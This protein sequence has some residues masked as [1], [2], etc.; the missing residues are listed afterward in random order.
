MI[1]RMINEAGLKSG[2]YAIILPM[3]SSEQ[4]TAIYY[5]TKSFR[6]A[7]IN[8][9]YGIKCSKDE[10]N[11]VPKADSILQAKLI[12]IT[13]GDQS[14]FMDVVQG[15]KVEQAIRQAHMKGATIAGTS[16]GAAVMSE[17]M[18]TGNQ[19]K[20]SEYTSTFATIE[21][22]NLET[23]Q[24]LGMIKNAIIDQH[25]VARSRHNRLLTAILES[26]ELTGIGIDESTAILVINNRAEV[27]GMSQVLVFKNRRK[28]VNLNLEKLGGKGIKVDIYLPGNSFRI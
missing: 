27:I 6:E 25:F 2:G 4:D 24:G 3:S 7:G 9:V 23:R 8:N 19:L 21:K 18:I 22:N 20:E 15:S 28:R 26:P 1:N 5:A 12:Y 13:G 11:S 16:A 17:R 14:R 10:A